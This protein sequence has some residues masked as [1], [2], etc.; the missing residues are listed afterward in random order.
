MLDLLAELAALKA[1][2]EGIDSAWLDP[3]WRRLLDQWESTP[4]SPE[5]YADCLHELADRQWH[6][7][8]RASE[9]V[10]RRVAVWISRV[11]TTQSED[12][13][14][15]CIGIVGSLGL[16]SCL[17]LIHSTL[18]DPGTAPEV[19]REIERELK[20][21]GDPPLNPWRDLGHPDGSDAV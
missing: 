9:S 16:D 2:H 19:A 20:S 15:A 14:D 8:E 18:V 13:L 10:Q 21:W 1:L 6:S 7:Y 3:Q 5:M 4:G 12:M 17:G 11:W